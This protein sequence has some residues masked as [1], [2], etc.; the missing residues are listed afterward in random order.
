MPGATRTIVINA[1]IEKVFD[2]ITQYE[3]YPEFLPE[4]K[5]IRTANR[6]GD[7]VDVHYK[8]DV[9]KTV[10]YSIRVV[11]ERPRRMAWTFIEGEVMKDNKG[12]WLLEAEGEGKTRAT[13]NVEMALGLLVPKAVVNALVDTSLPKMLDAFK[14]RAESP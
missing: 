11:E 4:V 6:K 10:R 12:S 13:Y 7:T 5:E 8:V 14:K 1:P 2:V 9:M 3:R